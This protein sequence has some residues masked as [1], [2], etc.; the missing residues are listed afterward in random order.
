M[1]KDKSLFERLDEIHSSQEDILNA[2][3]G[4]N[5]RVDN[6]DEKIASLERQIQSLRSQQACRPITRTQPQEPPMKTFAR[7]AHK[8]W[9]WFG[10]QKEFANRKTLAIVFE[11]VTLLL[12]IVST[13]ITGASCGAYSP[14][15]SLENIWIIMTIILLVYDSNATWKYDVD[16]YSRNDPFRGE[17]DDINM[18]F[19]QGGEKRVFTTFRIITIIFI[20]FNIIWIWMYQSNLSALATVFEILFGLSL[21]PQF[22]GNLFL[23]ADYC[24]CVLD[25]KNINTGEDVTLIR[26]PGSKT[27]D[28]EKG[29]KKIIPQLFE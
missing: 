25:G 19:P 13:I 24:I 1:P 8:S 21:I 29:V 18:Y 14:F 16:T 17:K 12:A 20:V 11:I 15:S 6:S 9:R 4:V 2:I 3:S 26:M 22:I 5:G 28:L 27:F 7:R 23:F 10:S